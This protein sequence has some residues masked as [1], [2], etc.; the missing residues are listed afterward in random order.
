MI[1]ITGSYDLKLSKEKRR[2]WNSNPEDDTL[3][4]MHNT[5]VLCS[6]L[7]AAVSVFSFTPYTTR[8]HSNA[9]SPE[10]HDWPVYGGSAEYL[11][12]SPLAQIS[13]ANVKQLQLAWTYDTGEQ[14]GLQ[15][16]PLVVHGVLYGISP[17]QKIFAVDAATGKELWKFDS[18]IKGMQP[19]RGLSYWSDKGD[20]RILVGVMNFLYAL[21][22]NTGKPIP[23]FGTDGR[24]DLQ[25]NLGREPR[26]QSVALTT[27]G[28]V[29]KDLII[30][31]GRNPETLPAPPGDIRAYDVRTGKL[32][33]SFHTIPHP[34]EFGYDTWPKDAWKTSGAANNWAGM[35]LDVQRGIVYVSTGSA[36]SDFYGADRIGN[37]LFANCLIALNA[38][39][40]ERIWHFQAVRHDLWDRDFPSAP[41]LVSL[42]RD[43]KAVDA[44]VQTSKQGFLF[45]FDRV[46]GKPLVPIEYRKYPASTLPGE[47]AANEQGL[48]TWPVPYARQ[49]L[50]EDMLTTRTPEAHQWVLDR[51]RASIHEGQFV[52]FR[53]GTDTIV[54]PGFDGAAE[55]GGPAVD[56]D[57]DIIYVNSNEM[58]WTASLFEDKGER[59][60]KAIYL[61]QCAVCHGE[62]MH[63]A[64]PDIPSLAAIGDRRSAADIASSIHG[65]KGR[66][67]AFPNLYEDQL[68]GL[69]QFLL[70]G[71]NKGVSSSG[72]LLP[73]MKYRLTGYR[74][75]LDPDG[76]P[77]IAPPWGTLNAIDLDTGEYKWKINFGQYPELAAKGMKNTGSE[78]YGGPIV[79][80]GGLLFIGATNYDRKFHAFDKS[81][82]ELLWET[83]LPFAGNATPVT[84]SV[85]GRQY[86]VIAAGGGKDPRS[87]SGGV[88]IAFAL[89]IHDKN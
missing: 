73:G 46:T 44:V 43:G 85:N 66:M 60:A 37:D 26:F 54:F 82:G 27:P 8:A 48:P 62:N 32:R 41:V 89:P 55:W 40:G 16:S 19:N 5:G 45:I 53:V 15:T 72:T 83:S 78:N 13:R 69:V 39:T 21:D 59:G 47:V 35:S 29:Y 52:P 7:L 74:R 42:K 12:Y 18:G 75:F 57:S 4:H 1:Q 30:V 22:A 17:T 38:E 56:P 88:Y 71:E 76:Y 33:W 28:I 80:A 87:P 64:P 68:S 36:A 77:A 79:T 34:G 25:E 86:V 23:S 49:T 31:G 58:A 84:Y 9:A 81:T 61:S 63:G 6:S 11:H 65:G 2:Q 20:R 70:T 3:T 50:T 14:G 51:F 10:S 67:P 24:V